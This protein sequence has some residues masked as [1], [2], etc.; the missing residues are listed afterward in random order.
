MYIKGNIKKEKINKI[1]IER[2][3]DPPKNPITDRIITKKI[4]KAQNG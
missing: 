3:I 1:L 2:S 4:G